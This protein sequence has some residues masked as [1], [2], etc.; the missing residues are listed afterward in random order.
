MER[1]AVNPELLVWARETAGLE[2]DAAARKLG[3]TDTKKHS[4]KEKLARIEAGADEVSRAT[5]VKM[6]QQYHRPL[7]AFYLPKPPRQGERGSDFRTLPEERRREDAPT[8]DALVRD[9]R[10]RQALVRGLLEDDEDSER[11]R[12]VGSVTLDTAVTELAETIASHSC[13][14]AVASF[15]FRTS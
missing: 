15:T 3:F 5:L 1:S 6:S 12:F 4:A 9:I 11:L 2:I 14:W 8:L 7:L 13:R 10:S